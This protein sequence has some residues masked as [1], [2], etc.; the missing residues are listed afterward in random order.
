MNIHI[1]KKLVS[2]IAA[3]G[4]ITLKP[5]FAHADCA[6]SDLTGTWYAYAGAMLRCKVKVNSSG[7]IVASK[8]S[9]R[10]NDET[11]Q[12]SA[13]ASGKMDISDHCL[14]S[15]KITVCDAGCANLKIEHG[16]IERD[17]NM[18]VL[19]VNAPAYDPTTSISLV[20]VKK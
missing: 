14:I 10:F 7:S 11:G 9:C 19:E 18:F 8:S 16:R 20:G 3:L 15:G 1:S 2:I 13:S 12:Y 5:V 4:L 6:Q 17:K